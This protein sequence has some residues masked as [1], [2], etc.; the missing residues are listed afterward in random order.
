[1][2]G[3]KSFIS[4]LP[5]TTRLSISNAK[6]I[7]DF[8]C[9]LG[10]EQISLRELSLFGR[11][12]KN[13]DKAT[14]TPQEFLKFYRTCMK[15]IIELNLAGKMTLTESLSK[16]ILQKI[17][18]RYIGQIA[19]NRNGDIYTCDEGRM[20]ANR[21]VENF[22]VGNVFE[23]PY[24]DCLLSEMTCAVCNASCVEANPSY[25]N[26]VY[27]PIC[28]LCPVYSFFTQG[29][30]VGVSVILSLGFGDGRL[31]EI[32]LKASRPKSL[33]CFD[34]ARAI[35]KSFAVDCPEQT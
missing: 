32:L 20:M 12:G 7:V 22:R 34:L 27:N 30:Y 26:C 28:V 9:E 21:G 1:M 23:S 14:Y 10:V 33:A 31:E 6:E 15:Y 35:C 2:Y 4:A 11:V 3:E 16:M 18:G 17:F 8:Y 29:D 13:F 25:E 24:R 19:Y 5:T